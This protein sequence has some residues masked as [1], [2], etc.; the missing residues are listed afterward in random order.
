MKFN[1][2][3]R[4]YMRIPLK[5]SGIYEP[6]NR[7]LNAE[8]SAYEY[9]IGKF[10]EECERILNN[11]FVLTADDENIIKRVSLF[12][13][14]VIRDNI[15]FLRQ[16]L[17]EKSKIR[18]SSPSDMEKRLTAAGIKGSMTVGINEIKIEAE[19]YMGVTPETALAEIKK[20]MPVFVSVTAE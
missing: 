3:N 10:C 11:A 7:N 5:R 17:F 9:G 13:N 2:D 1:M 20:Y 8:L 15:E 4:I 14:H 16:Q 18:G 6:E 12:R 19:E